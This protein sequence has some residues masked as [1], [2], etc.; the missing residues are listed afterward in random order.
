MCIG[1]FIARKY[2][3]LFFM[4]VSAWARLKN[5][6]FPSCFAWRISSLTTNSTR[7]QRALKAYHDFLHRAIASPCLN[8]FLAF[9]RR[10]WQD[11]QRCKRAPST[12]TAPPPPP[13]E[14][15]RPLPQRRQVRDPF[16]SLREKAKVCGLTWWF[17]TANGKH[18]SGLRVLQQ[19]VAVGLLETIN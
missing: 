5:I 14:W 2:D 4:C 15:T 11:V 7:L 17:G 6:F 13:L 8:I 1:V 9:C 18:R 10:L 16:G 19:S 12:G 3:S